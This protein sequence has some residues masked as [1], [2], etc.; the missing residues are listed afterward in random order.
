MCRAEC[1]LPATGQ[2]D[3]G[4]TPV[5]RV[6]A[7]DG[8]AVP[9]EAVYQLARCTHGDA[10]VVAEVLYSG[11]LGVSVDH[12]Q[13]MK[14]RQADQAFAP[15]YLVNRIPQRDLLPHQHIEEVHEQCN[16]IT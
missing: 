14:L 5:G 7:P 10:D 4:R 11:L 6:G 1:L 13:S 8:Q 16:F 3:Q 9:L 15:Q 2:R 12:P